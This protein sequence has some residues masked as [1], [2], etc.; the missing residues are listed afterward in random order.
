MPQRKV[1]ICTELLLYLHVFFQIDAVWKPLGE[2]YEGP[3]QVISRHEKFFKIDRNC[4]V[5]TTDIK[6]FK[7]AY[8]DDGIMHTIS[9]LDVI[10]ALLTIEASTSELSSQMAVPDMISNEATVSRSNKKCTSTLSDH[11]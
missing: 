6:R 1:L 10:P 4:R 11:D 7:A 5:N 8:V 3:L 2:P 9:R